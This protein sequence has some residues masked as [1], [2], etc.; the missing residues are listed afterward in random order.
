MSETGLK[1]QMAEEDGNAFAILGRAQHVMRQAALPEERINQFLEEAR[2][3][4]YDQLIQT[5]IK[6]FDTR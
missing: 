3:G 5:C 1:L 6:W 2:R 4:D